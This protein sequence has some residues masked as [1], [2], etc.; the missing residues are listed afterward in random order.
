MKRFLKCELKL[1]VN[2]SRTTRIGGNNKS[3]CKL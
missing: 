3:K 1:D 2:G